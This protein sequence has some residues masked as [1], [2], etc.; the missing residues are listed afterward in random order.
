MGN[1]ENDFVFL[2]AQGRGFGTVVLVW[3]Y[4]G[5]GGSLRLSSS[6]LK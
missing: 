5:I 4:E 1:F 3:F 6:L 2:E